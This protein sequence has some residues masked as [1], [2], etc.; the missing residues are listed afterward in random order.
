[1]K[2]C[3]I[4]PTL[5]PTIPPLLQES[6]S[7]RLENWLCRRMIWELLHPLRSA[8]PSQT[9]VPGPKA[10]HSYVNELPTQVHPVAG[11]IRLNLV[12]FCASIAIQYRKVTSMTTRV[13]SQFGMHYS[14]LSFGN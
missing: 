14:G 1:M 10:W 5:L 4:T 11:S 13:A 8:V 6:L 2:H 3:S 12:Q 7:P 9:V